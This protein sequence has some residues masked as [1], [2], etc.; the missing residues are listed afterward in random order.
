METQQ[1]PDKF[2]T[3]LSEQRFQMLQDIATELAED[4]VF[5]TSFEIVARL[6]K[7][8][9]N[10][11]L[12]L[13]QIAT[14]V[15]VEPLMSARLTSL[16]NSAK[17]AKD[18]RPVKNVREAAQRLGIKVVRTTVTAIA[19]NQLLRSK[20]TVKFTGLA[21]QLW[22]HSLRTAAAAELVA[23]NM[24]NIAPEDAM[25]AGLIHDLG[26]FYMLYRAT[27]YEE[28]R[29]RPNTIRYLI[30]QW[31]ESIGHAVLIALGMPEDIAEAVREHDQ[32]RHIADKPR[33]LGDVIYI[34][35]RLAGGMFDGVGIEPETDAGAQPALADDYLQLADTVTARKCELEA[36]FA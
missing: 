35:N 20:D 1:I 16:A 3:A 12:S 15:G 24:T 18:G 5:P 7:V 8:A 4:V 6:R 10:P 26:A 23:R 31:H 27:Q 32:P 28:L 17:F 21:V 13:D 33:N 34:A 11:N 29:Q 22:Q 30:L 14:C 9:L 36:V 2:G 25:L 19:M